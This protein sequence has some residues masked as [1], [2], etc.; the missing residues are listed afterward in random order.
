MHLAAGPDPETGR[1]KADRE[2]RVLCLRR[3]EPGCCAVAGVHVQPDGPTDVKQGK[4][5][6]ENFY[7][8]AGED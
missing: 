2:Q 5:E 8:Y 1:T 3:S 7:T 4:R 6:E